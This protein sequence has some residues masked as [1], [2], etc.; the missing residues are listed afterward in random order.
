MDSRLRVGLA[1]V[2]IFLNLGQL[3]GQELVVCLKH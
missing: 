3:S 2:R 1:I